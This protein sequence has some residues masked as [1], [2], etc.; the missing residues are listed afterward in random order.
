LISVQSTTGEP[1]YGE[2]D[3]VALDAILAASRP[4]SDREEYVAMT[5]ELFDTLVNN[6]LVSDAGAQAAKAGAMYDRCYDPGGPGRQL[7]AVLASGDRAAGLAS[8]EVPTLVIH[9]NRDPLI[10]ISGGRRTA[11]LVP[12]ATFVEI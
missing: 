6:P 10:G 3:P 7:A 1:G 2:P 5:V 4:V 11:E 12:G 8:L 9:G